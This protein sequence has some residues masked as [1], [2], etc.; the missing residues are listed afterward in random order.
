MYL[1]Y[2]ILSPAYNNVNKGQITFLLME[3]LKYLIEKLHSYTS[4]RERLC[5]PK[6]E[7]TLRPEFDSIHI[8]PYRPYRIVYRKSILEAL[9]LPVSP[10][11]EET[12]RWTRLPDS[13]VNRS[14]TH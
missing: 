4:Y 5:G 6:E 7:E 11:F 14:L 8:S 9:S 2:C 1:E 10:E 3:L 12:S 13:L